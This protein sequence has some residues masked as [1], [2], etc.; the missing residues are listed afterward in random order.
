MRLPRLPGGHATAGVVALLACALGLESADAAVVGAT[1]PQLE[2]AL[3]ISNAQL[4]LLA[5]ISTF[6][7]AI[8]TLPAG[9][10]ADRLCRVR[11]LAVA[12]A[13]WGV[14]MV[15]GAAAQDYP[16]LLF[17]RTG[18]G[19]VV[20]AAGPVIASLT[21]DFFAPTERAKIYGYILSGELLG[22]GLGFFVSGTIAGVLSWRWA[23]VAL[24]IPAAVLALVIWKRLPEPARGQQS[25]AGSSDS[26]QQ[27]SVAQRAASARRVPPVETRVLRQDPGA[28]RLRSAVRYV[29]RIP[30]NNWLIAAS[31]VG[32]FFFAGLRTFGVVFVRGHFGLGQSV[33]VTVL[34]VAGLGSLAGVLL[35]GRLADRMVA[36]GRLT[37]RV[38]VG[39]ASYFV[40]AALLLPALVVP[41]L[42]VA[43]P[44]LVVAAASLSAPNPPLD[45]A[46]LDI[47]PSR[48]WGRAEGVRTLVRQIAQA[49]APLVFGI[50]AD[51]LGGQGGTVG[52]HSAVSAASARALQITFLI[53]L[54]PLAANGVL[55]LRARRTYAADMATAVESESASHR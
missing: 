45:A 2:G 46:R 18:L 30:T 16:W 52:A 24:A 17:S 8:G 35:S 23:F 31:S 40:A 19:V 48:L 15:V 26:G 32:Y 22:A 28:L 53:M 5:A 41:S 39:A 36:K 1:G 55:L 3:H 50:V 12:V 54:I 20:A 25:A 9:A 42:S 14:A 21:G 38:V 51:A 37:A 11:M 33:A 47:I 7:G 4:G 34:F 43:L 13:L 44:L 10:L 29:L 49:G 6:V 27:E